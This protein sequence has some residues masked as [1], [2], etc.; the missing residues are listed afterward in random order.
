MSLGS[1]LIGSNRRVGRAGSLSGWGLLLG[2][3]ARVCNCQLVCFDIG[4]D[5]NTRNYTV[6]LLKT[7]NSLSY[8]L[9]CSCDVCS[10]DEG[11]GFDVGAIFVVSADVNFCPSRI[12][13]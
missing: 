10:Q 9:D 7:G 6:T 4:V 1:S 2:G 5:W 8:F 11:V 3:W 13:Q 12:V